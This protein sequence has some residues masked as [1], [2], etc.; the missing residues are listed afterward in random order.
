MV[1][2]RALIRDY[3]KHL[4]NLRHEL[5]RWPDESVEAARL[6]DSIR[7]YEEHVRDLEAVR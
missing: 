3:Q 7:H 2:R 5:E 6:R 4:E 1:L